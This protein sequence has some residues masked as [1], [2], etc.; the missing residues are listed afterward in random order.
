MSKLQTRIGI[1][2]IRSGSKRIK[3]KNIRKFIDKPLFW[4]TANALNN[5]T[6]IDYF[7]VSSDSQYYLDLVDKY[8]FNKVKYHLREKQFSRDT[9]STE[10]V[11]NSVI[12][13]FNLKDNDI[14]TL[15]QAT[16][17][18][19][20]AIDIDSAIDVFYKHDYNSVFSVADCDKFIW[21]MNNHNTLEPINYDYLNRKRSQTFDNSLY[22]ENGGIYVTYVSSYIKYNNRLYP[23]IGVYVMPFWT[24]FEI[25]TEEDWQN[26]EALMEVS[27]IGNRKY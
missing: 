23:R 24:A 6:H 9:S 7:I 16:S 13:E 18:W 19:V 3:N 5:A 15:V 27:P 10:S 26:L 20:T 8:K 17:P 22:I 4:W 2:P 11:V 21:G 1:L 14:I 25:D 12:E